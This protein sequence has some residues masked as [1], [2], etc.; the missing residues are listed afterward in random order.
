MIL[1]NST[2]SLEESIAKQWVEWVK[3][4]YFPKV[5]KTGKAIECKLCKIRG[6][7]PLEITYSV[8]V[9]FENDS[10]LDDFNSNEGEHINIEM[11]RL[12]GGK[13]AHFNTVLEII[14]INNI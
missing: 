10:S 12:F 3:A 9:I 1:Y 8:Q 14:H 13:Y 11:A 7:E 5:A 2:I 4:Y 6:H